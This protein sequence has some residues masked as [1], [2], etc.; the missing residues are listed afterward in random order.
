M[1]NKNSLNSTNPSKLPLMHVTIFQRVT[2]VRENGMGRAMPFSRTF[3][4]R[5]K[6]V[7]CINGSLDGL[8]EFRLFLFAMFKFRQASF[9][10]FAFPNSFPFFPY[11]Y[12]L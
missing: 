2:K 6:I 7:T 10:H 9:P 3:V 1:A 5:W 12:S 8:V 4:T 11:I